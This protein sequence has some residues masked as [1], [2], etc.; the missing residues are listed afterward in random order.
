MHAYG[1]DLDE[2]STVLVQITI[3]CSIVCTP[4]RVN[5]TFPNEDNT[6]ALDLTTAVHT[7]YDA[8]M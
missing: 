7:T 5:D 3:V 1:L 2:H 4:T 8:A 6:R